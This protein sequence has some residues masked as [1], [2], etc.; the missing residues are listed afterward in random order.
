MPRRKHPK[1]Q[2]KHTFMQHDIIYIYVDIYIY[3]NIDYRYYPRNLMLKLNIVERKLV[4]ISIHNYI[5]AGL[6]VGQGR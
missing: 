6:Q 5:L 4:I 1:K 3:K 2:E